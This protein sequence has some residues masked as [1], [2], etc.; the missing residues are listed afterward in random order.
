M[1]Q[2]Q[3]SVDKC[4][5]CEAPKPGSKPK[6]IDK[7]MANP[8]PLFTKVNINNK[9]LDVYLFV[10]VFSSQQLVYSSR[11]LTLGKFKIEFV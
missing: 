3:Q 4:V 7:V 11:F 10:Y 2:N 9:Q 8:L 6:M 1:I 5:A